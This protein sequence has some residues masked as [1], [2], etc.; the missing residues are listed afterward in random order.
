MQGIEIMTPEEVAKFLQLAT[1]TVYQLA[2]E[3]KLP[4]F[5]IGASVRFRRTDIE[6]FI[7][8]QVSPARV[9]RVRAIGRR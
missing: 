5:K 7:D 8:R 2:R 9:A 4:A 6:A 1:S 3:G